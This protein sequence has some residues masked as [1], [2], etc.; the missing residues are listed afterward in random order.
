MCDVSDGLVQDLGH[1]AR[2]SAVQICIDTPRL[3]VAPG[4]RTSAAR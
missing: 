1:V 4:F 3:E 2:A